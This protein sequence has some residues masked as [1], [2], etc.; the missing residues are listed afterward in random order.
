MLFSRY[1]AAA[2]NAPHR[3]LST[4]R[5]A[6]V[7]IV[8]LAVGL[9]RGVALAEG[10]PKPQASPAAHC[11]L[12]EVFAGAE[13]E[14]SAKALAFVEKLRQR[15]PGLQVKVHD[16]SRDLAAH[17]RLSELSRRW[18]FEKPG[19]PSFYVYD[20]FVRG[21]RDAETTGPQLE[22][23][24]TITVFV[25]AG[26]PHCA[27]AKAYLAKLQPHYPAFRIVYHDIIQDNAARSRMEALTQRFKVQTPGLPTFFLCGRLQVG[28]LSEDLTGRK[29]EALLQKAGAPCEA[30]TPAVPAREPAPK[31]SRRRPRIDPE[32]LR[33]VLVLADPAAAA[34]LAPLP[35]APEPASVEDVDEPLR[36]PDVLPE[37]LAEA[38][39]RPEQS[40]PNEL[41]E[42]GI[43]VPVFGRLRVKSIGLPAFTFL[44]GLVDG[45]NPCA[46]WVLIFLLSLLVNLKDRRKIV[47]IAGTFVFVSGLAYFAFMAAWLNVF[48]LIGFARPAQ[49]TLGL[50]AIL[51]GA[52][53]LK[54]FFAFGRGI[55]L[56]IPQ[57]A[58]PGIYER[59]RR[60]IMAKYL[61]AALAGAVV[62]A[63]LVNTIELLCTA[64]LPA[65]YTQILTMHRLPRW[66]N[67]LYLL[68]YNVAYMLDDT[69][70]VTIAVTTL[71]HRKLQES[72]GRWLKL[73]SG[74][75]ILILGLLMVFR[76]EWLV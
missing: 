25:R 13:N 26:C 27:A 44:I 52:V 66:E 65:M 47:I 50:L 59:V 57:A 64:G 21:F 69:V 29:L 12:L 68:L 11:T 49:I 36:P 61:A 4:A 19:V 55:S 42:S 72:E 3:S 18:G 70:M 53:N 40:E 10:D 24:L 30:A 6:A 23:L 76:P 46:M 34:R 56:S 62:L 38:V 2:R 20:Q 54:D 74:L 33:N 39:P 5:W 58:K 75:V 51:I 37:Q 60:I 15:H 45:F 41:D 1:Q 8:V 35:A 73:L 67:Y 71:S 63:V 48:L 14:S 7:S 43:D 32:R 16:V 17:K 22:D 31:T 9:I 28:F